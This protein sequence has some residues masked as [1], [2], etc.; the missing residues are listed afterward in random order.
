MPI[1]IFPDRIQIGNFNLFEGN[2]GIQFDGQAIAQEFLGRSPT[3]GVES[4]YVAGGVND[5]A[6]INTI[7]KYSLVT[8]SNGSDVGDLSS[9]KRGHAG[10]CSRTNGYIFGGIADP[11]TF[12]NTIEKFPF[13]VDTNSID[14]GDLIQAID[15]NVGNASEVSGYSSSGRSA[16][17]TAVNTIQKFPFAT[18]TNATDI[19]D[20]SQTR[21]SYASASSPAFGYSFGGYSPGAFPTTWQTIDKFPFSVDTNASDV[22]DL[23]GSQRTSSGGLGSFTD[24]YVIGGEASPPGAKLTFIQKFPFASNLNSVATGA[25]LTAAGQQVPTSA[26]PT[27]G[28]CGGGD[29]P[30]VSPVGA[31]TIDK[32][33][34]ATASNATDVGDLAQSVRAGNAGA[35]S[36]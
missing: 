7:Q 30:G 18:D 19:G 13:S 28:Y 35:I 31:N 33:N 16:P 2:G 32:F 3:Q 21:F 27:H 11:S 22:G 8:D 34:F 5:P 9:I 1:R 4:G 17:T 36:S 26:S 25:N 23:T 29:R 10:T 14:V 15:Q 20:T 24:A 6:N 12:L